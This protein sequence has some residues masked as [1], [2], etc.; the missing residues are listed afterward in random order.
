M[1][2]IDYKHFS[3]IEFRVGKVIKAEDIEESDNLIKLI[4][5]FGDKGERT[6]L[7]GIKKW[8]KPQDL[9]GNLY[10]FVCNLEP[11]EMFGE[12][13]QGMIM[14]AEDEGSDGL[15]LVKPENEISPGTRVH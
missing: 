12:R 11:K 15:A 10:I 6:I 5:D 7:S 2:S 4:V 1:T 9:E 8:Y 14:A 3:E 13:S